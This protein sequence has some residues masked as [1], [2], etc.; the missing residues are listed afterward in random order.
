MNKKGILLTELLTIVIVIVIIFIICINSY[1]AIIKESKHTIGDNQYNSFINAAKLYLSSNSFDN[2]LLEVT[3]YDLIENNYLDNIVYIDAYTN[4][5]LDNNSSVIIDYEANTYEFIPYYSVDGL[6]ISY[7]S[8][9][10][11]DNL[12]NNIICM[13]GKFNKD[14][15]QL[16]N[17]K[18]NVQNYENFTI[19]FHSK[20]ISTLGAVYTHN[21]GLITIYDKKI[22]LSTLNEFTSYDIIKDSDKLIIYINGNKIY[23]DDI[24][25]YFPYINIP[26]INKL[27]NIRFYNKSLT[28]EEIIS[29]YNISKRRFN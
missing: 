25:S 29:N 27:Y 1:Y 10:Q 20:N 18:I 24:Y 23:N 6:L 2:R 28:R 17:L 26:N 11:T 19:S 13:T 16:S 5:V 9:K 7:D 3:L 14:H 21:E 15:Y 12:C 8:Y 22:P 4:N